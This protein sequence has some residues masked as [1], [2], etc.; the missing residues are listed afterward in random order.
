MKPSRRLGLHLISS[1]AIAAI[2]TAPLLRAD[3]AATAAPAPAPTPAPAPALG[4]IVAPGGIASENPPGEIVQTLLV[5]AKVDEAGVRRAVVNAS[6]DRDWTVVSAK[7]NPMVLKR[8]RGGHEANLFI[9]I[10]ATEIQIFSDSYT[11]NGKGER[12]KRSTPTS[13]VKALIKVMLAKLNTESPTM[14]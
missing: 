9:K 2:F 10:S 11:I 7:D 6:L 12:Q 1:L 13:W 5:P 3:D 8:V 4:P 14:H